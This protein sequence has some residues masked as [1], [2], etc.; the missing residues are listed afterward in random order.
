[1]RGRRRGRGPTAAAGCRSGRFRGGGGR[2]RP[3]GWRLLE[4]LSDGGGRAGARGPAALGTRGAARPQDEG[5]AGRGQPGEALLPVEDEQPAIEEFADLGAAAGVGAAA[6]APGNLHPTRAEADGVVAGDDAWIATA[7]ETIELAGR[8][9][10]DAGRVGRGP[11][12]AAVEVGEEG[13]QVGI[14][15]LEG[16]DPAEAQL[17]DEAVLQGLPQTLDA[18]LGLRGVGLDIA[19]AE[20]LQ[21]APEVSGVLGA[22]QFFFER[23]VVVVA[24]EDVEAVAVDRERQA[25]LPEDLVE[26]D[27]VA[28][29]ILGGAEVQ[30]EEPR[31]GVVD[32]PQECH[33]RPT[34]FEPVKGAAIDLHQTAGGGFPRAPTAVEPGPTAPPRGLLRRAPE[35]AH[36]GPADGQVVLH[37]QSHGDDATVEAEIGPGP[38]ARSPN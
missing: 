4:G 3:A 38:A 29:E 1:M 27:G 31:G 22:V 7:E 25:V 24:H 5:G 28:V 11:G 30:G 23:P 36:R 15:R 37:L 10:P 18:A 9:P 35:P 19:D 14:G 13:G 2:R 16:G 8:P 26:D 6:G 33:R 12:E 21:E 20:L 34:L 17:A 32:G